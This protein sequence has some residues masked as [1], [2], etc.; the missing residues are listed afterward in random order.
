MPSAVIFDVDGTLIDS[1]DL[2]AQAW[3][4]AFEQFGKQPSF[5]DVRAQIGKGA[6]QLMPVFLSRDELRRFGEQLEEF[7]GQL[8][9]REYLSRVRAFPEVRALFERVRAEGKQIALASSAPR[10]E[11]ARY[12]EVANIADLIDVTTSA[13]DV[14]RSKPH[15]DVFCAALAR[16]QLPAADAVVVGDSP[17]DVQAASRAGARCVGLLCGGFARELLES[18]G[19]VAIY[20]DP[21]DLHAHFASSP[22][23]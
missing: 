7:R 16:L 1:V 14:E 3:K 6:D 17:Y 20:R 11:L 9:K 2:H 4:D 5:A 15:P 8:Y 13:D 18:A 10:D 22:L 19:A 23:G 12:V 21:A